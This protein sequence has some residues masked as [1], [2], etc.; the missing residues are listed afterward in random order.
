[1]RVWCGNQTPYRLHLL[2]TGPS[3]TIVAKASE[4]MKYYRDMTLWRRFEIVCD[5]HYKQRKIKGAVLRLREVDGCMKHTASCCFC[6]LSFSSAKLS[7][8]NFVNF[9]FLA[10]VRRTRGVSGRC[11]G[12]ADT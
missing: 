3:N 6:W 1:M 9:R 5:Q 2:E 10:Y 4:L 8:L 12:G 11:G 7:D